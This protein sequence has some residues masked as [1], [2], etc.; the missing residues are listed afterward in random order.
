MNKLKPLTSVAIRL[1]VEL[2]PVESCIRAAERRKGHDV[3]SVHFHDVGTEVI[4]DCTSMI[5]D[6]TGPLSDG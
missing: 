3:D 2:T 6:D 1:A 4:A 5:I